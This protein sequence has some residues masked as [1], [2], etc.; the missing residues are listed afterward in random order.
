GRDAGDQ[1]GQGG[2]GPE[3]GRGRARAADDPAARGR[4]RGRDQ[5]PGGR[6]RPRG[7]EPHEPDGGGDREDEV[8]LRR[9]DRQAGGRAEAGRRRGGG[10]REEDDGNGPEQPV[11]DEDGGVPERRQRLPAVHVGRAAEPANAATAV[12]QRPGDVLDEHG[13]QGHAAPGA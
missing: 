12:P 10:E 3:R 8:R 13:R 6:H 2:D 4:G 9:P 5:A 11:P 1:Q 7:A